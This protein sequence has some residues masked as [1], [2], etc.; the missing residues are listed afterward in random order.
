MGSQRRMDGTWGL[1]VSSSHESC[2]HKRFQLDCFARHI[3]QAGRYSRG[4]EPGSS[5]AA[6]LLCGPIPIPAAQRPSTFFVVFQAC[7]SS[8]W[9]SAIDRGSRSNRCLFA[10]GI[11]TGAETFARDLRATDPFCVLSAAGAIVLRRFTTLTLGIVGV[12]D[13]FL[14]HRRP[15][16]PTVL[17]IANETL[18]VEVCCNECGAAV[19][20]Q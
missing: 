17:D 20:V 9:S 18:E 5:G 10:P 11:S 2:T 16:G 13:S 12:E 15:H 6:S 19:G 14:E 8:L 3:A 1:P 7:L 4:G